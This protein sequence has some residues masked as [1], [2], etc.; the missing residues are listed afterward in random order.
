VKQASSSRDTGQQSGAIP[1]ALQ[2]RAIS[3]G[4][5]GQMVKTLTGAILACGGWVLSRSASDCGLIDILF[6][7]ERQ[8]CL[9]IYSILIA[10]GLELSQSA[11]IRFTELCQ[12]IRMGYQDGGEE[13]IS[14]DLEV[15]TFML[16][17]P[18]DRSVLPQA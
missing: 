9:E 4:E 3:R 6:E 14:V 5:P 16:N 8:S 1:W 10:A 15:Q 2:I 13:I 18:G 11:H 17:E 12:C 7:F